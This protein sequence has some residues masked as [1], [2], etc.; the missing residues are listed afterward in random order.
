MTVTSPIRR[1]ID[2]LNIYKLCVNKNIFLFG[3][4]AEQFY[5]NWINKLDYINTT[6]KNI[7]KVQSK[8]NILSVCLKNNHTIYKGN[9]FDKGI[10]KNKY[11][12]QVYIPDLNVYSKIYSMD[13]LDETIEYT[14]KLYV[15]QNEGS[16][17]NK[18]KL[19]II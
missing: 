9:I 1:L 5:N 11:K 6:S 3:N 17:K 16:F 8:C 12:Y 18:I 13:E 19:D 2:I 4:D 7:R 10:L 14:F 15:F